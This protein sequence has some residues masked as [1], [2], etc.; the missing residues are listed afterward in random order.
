MVN[1]VGIIHRG[2]KHVQCGSPSGASLFTWRGSGGMTLG[3]AGKDGG[4]QAAARSEV[5]LDD[6]PDWIGC[7]DD[8]MEHLVDGIFI[9]DT[10]VAVGE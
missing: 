6:A 3:P 2:R 9:E 5:S 10:E 7:L 4:V 1:D 8:V